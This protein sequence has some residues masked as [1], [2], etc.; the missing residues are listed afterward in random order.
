MDVDHSA[1]EGLDAAA[2]FVD[3]VLEEAGGDRSRVIG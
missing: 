1:H 2:E 3:E